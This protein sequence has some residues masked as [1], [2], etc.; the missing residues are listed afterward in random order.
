MGSRG[1]V[2]S[3][4]AYKEGFFNRHGLLTCHL[5]PFPSPAILLLNRTKRFALSLNN[6]ML[7]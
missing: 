2:D 3:K 1:Y 7:K 4:S 6:L 5:P